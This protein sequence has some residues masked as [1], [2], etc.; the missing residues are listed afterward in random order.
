[1]RRLNNLPDVIYNG[2]NLP[3]VITDTYIGGGEG[4]GDFKTYTKNPYLPNSRNYYDENG[5]G[6]YVNNFNQIKRTDEI[7][8]FI[9]YKDD[10]ILNKLI[11]Y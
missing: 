9:F 4:S 8:G 5:I 11:L 10:K 3:D 2:E 7:L 6:H 1:M